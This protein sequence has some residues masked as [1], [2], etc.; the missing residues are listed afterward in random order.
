M[1]I[2][3]VTVSAQ[4]INFLV[5]VWLLKRFLYTPVIRAMDR[6]ERRI[7]ERLEDAEEKKAEADQRASRYE[8]KSE[9]L[10]QRREE[11][12]EDA[13]ENAETER[14]KLLAEAREQSEQA[15]EEW[16]REVGEEK[17]RF[18]DEVGK[19]GADAIQAIAA[20]AL[21]DLAS[22][23]L[24]DAMASRLVEALQAEDA[25]EIETLAASDDAL[26]VLSATDLEA[27]T[28]SRLT[29]A[30]HEHIGKDIEVSYDTA[31]EVVCGIVLKGDGARLGWC[32]ADYLDA[33]KEAV[34]EAL[35]KTASQRKK[36]GG[37]TQTGQQDNGGNE[38]DGEEEG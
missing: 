32:V 21:G 36:G 27:S 37:T 17:A 13:R 15:R 18:L 7:A 33:L 12:L 29:R 22:R 25:A 6:R 24:E 1:Q 8:E 5:L 35:E 19:H 16:M 2:D 30:I 9:A 20:R 28:R 34:D 31:P 23:E 26:Q 4:I 14:K 11:L 38:E 10:E 3:W